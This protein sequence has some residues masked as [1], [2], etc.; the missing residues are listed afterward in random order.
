[1]VCPGR[2]DWWA[3]VSKNSGPSQNA[4]PKNMK[5][6]SDSFWLMLEGGHRELWGC[7]KVLRIYFTQIWRTYKVFVLL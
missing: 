7:T 1:M 5:P 2:L 4:L 3:L 6:S